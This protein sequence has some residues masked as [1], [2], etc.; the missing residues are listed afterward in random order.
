MPVEQGL[1]SLVLRTAHYF[2]CLL[3]GTSGV[4]AAPYGSQCML[5]DLETILEPISKVS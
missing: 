5:G 1:E 3:E 2:L 4:S